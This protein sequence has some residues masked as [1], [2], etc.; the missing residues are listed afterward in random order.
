MKR[1]DTRQLTPEAQEAIRRRVV[2]AVADGMKQGEAARL[3]GVSRASVNAW[4]KKFREN[5]DDGLAA[6]ARGRPRVTRLG[7]AQAADTIAAMASA[8]PDRHGIKAPLWS[9]DALCAYV[10]KK[11]GHRIS[12]WTAAR[13][14]IRWGFLPKRP[15]LSSLEK[16]PAAVRRWF[17]KEY[18]KLRDQARRER[19]EILWAG[20]ATVFL[21]AA[22]PDDAGAPKEKSRRAA[23]KNAVTMISAIS[24][25]NQLH[26]MICNAITPAIFI[27]FMDRLCRSGKS[28][29]YLMT[30]P[31]PA[32]NEPE[33]ARWLKKNTDRIVMVPI[34]KA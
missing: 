23:T 8:T 15:L 14:L 7:A 26:F 28:R 31:H 29:V 5:G 33:V 12:V 4:M 27:D 18:P 24:N 19:A 34:P 3:F 9:R 2:R 13:Y 10:E 20:A 21:N 16:S 11:H 1:D 30:A 17:E 6:G 25:R 32:C 22:Q